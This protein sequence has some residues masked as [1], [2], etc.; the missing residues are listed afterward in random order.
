MTPSEN[1]SL[2]PRE[3]GLDTSPYFSFY[4]NGTR[5]F[6]QAGARISFASRTSAQLF[7]PGLPSGTLSAGDTVTVKLSG[8]VVYSGKVEKFSE[9]TYG[10]VTVVDYTC[11]DGWDLLERKAFRQKWSVSNGRGTVIEL[12]SSH[13]VLNTDYAGLSVTIA[14]QISSI[15]SYASIGVSGSGIP[16]A[17]LP[18]DET[19]NIT[20][21]DAIRRSL[22]FFPKVVARFNP[23]DGKIVFSSPSSTDA[24]YVGGDKTISRSKNYT[25]HPVVGVDIET[26]S[27][28]TSVSDDDTGVSI[29]TREYTHQTSGDVD[30]PDCLHVFIPLAPGMSSSSFE[31]LEVV[32]EALP[33]LTSVSFWKEKHPRLAN[34]PSNAITITDAGRSSATYGNITS[35]DIGALQAFGMNAELVHC[36]CW[37]TITT[38]DDIEEK[39]YLTMD[40]IMTDASGGTHTRQTGSSSTAAETLPDGLAAAIL[41]QRGG[42][43]ES[44]EM[45]IRVDPENF[46]VV[47]DSADGLVLQNFDVDCDTL[48]ANLHFGHPDYLTPEDMRDLMS[49]F[50]Q[51]GQASNVP[52]RGEEGTTDDNAAKVAGGVMPL[53]TT[54]FAPGTKKKTTVQADTSGGESSAALPKV[55]MDASS[56]TTA[57]SEVISGERKIQLVSNG[58]GGDIVLKTESVPNGETIGVHTLTYKDKDGVEHTYCILACADIS[59]QDTQGGGGGSSGGG[60][61]DG[62]SSSQKVLVGLSYNTSTHQLIP[63]Y[64]VIT[65]AIEVTEP[66]NPAVANAAVFTATPLQ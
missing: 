35:N 24:S 40:F 56:T 50:R 15:C 21:A 5:F 64:K 18:P 54:E 33:L 65:G 37:A 22:R 1:S 51:R 19:S 16:S 46:P 62:S 27:V 47:G 8:N 53:T 45:T 31:T 61:G 11:L 17:T 44:E 49:G 66:D 4:R 39:L 12:D 34:V 52:I 3:N 23:V 20:C 26:E 43:L 25:A 55:V 63:E 13:V 2:P 48:V 36:H 28:D 29:S 30:S 42:T 60:S 14:E 38:V 57:K 10:D 41:A 6:P 58:S 32:T 59:I 9:R 7:L